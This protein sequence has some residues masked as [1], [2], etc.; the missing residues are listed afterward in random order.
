M[1]ILPN[2]RH[3]L[4]EVNTEQSARSWLHAIYSQHVTM[5]Y[6]GETA[7]DLGCES[8]QEQRCLIKDRNRAIPWKQSLFDV[9]SLTASWKDVSIALCW[10]DIWVPTPEPTYTQKCFVSVRTKMA[11]L[12]CFVMGVKGFCIEENFLW[13]KKERI[14][15]SS[16]IPN[17]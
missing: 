7:T 10:E 6:H 14:L 1:P 12:P 13:K 8:R 4:T 17:Y 11:A 15:A 5:T 2:N 3:S 16:S 9:P